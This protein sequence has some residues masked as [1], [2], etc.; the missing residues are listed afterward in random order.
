MIPKLGK[1]YYI[2]YTDKEAPEGSYFGIAR[3]V[4]EYQYS[5]SGERLVRP[6]YEFEHPNNEGEMCLSL[7]YEDEIVME[8]I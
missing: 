3:C 1:F 7:Y 8:A 2:D 4:K 6:L 5:E